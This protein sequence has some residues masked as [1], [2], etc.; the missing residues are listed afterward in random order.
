[1]KLVV[2]TP[3]YPPDIGGPATY[4]KILEDEL[5]KQ[6]VSVSVISFHTVRH[7]PK[8]IAHLVYAWKLFQALRSVDLLLALDPVSVGLPAAF[9]AF[10]SGKRFIVR[11]AGDYAWEQGKQR[12]GVKE[13]LDEF[14]Q[15]PPNRFM[16][17]VR[18]LRALQHVVASRADAV[19]VPSAYLKTIVTKWGIVPE[20]ITVVYN[21]FAGVPSLP[22][23]AEVRKRLGWS[24]P[25][26]FSSGR[27]VPWKGFGVLIGL[28]PELMRKHSGTKLYIAGS[29]PLLPE[30][31]QMVDDLGLGDMVTLLGDMPRE[32]LMAHVVAADCFVLN[33]GYEG[34]S[35][36]LLE[37]L[38]AG[39]PIVTTAVG[40]N[41][42]LIEHNV[43]GVLVDY[44]D[45]TALL[46]A[47][48]G[49]LT[50]T[51]RAR[52]MS[53]KG[54]QF[55]ANFTVERMVKDTLLVLRGITTK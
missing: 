10:L 16:A 42:E 13:N 44:N 2:A 26:I 1:M 8:G 5:P 22:L 45:A 50:D 51:V 43:T 9:A 14:V 49:V 23:R 52:E 39:T 47:I 46:R 34:F 32:E 19:I 6:G 11:I 53:E 24:A 21:A 3:L 4:A 15:M 7:L 30:L 33:T 29:G 12:F 38:S 27:L 36:Q 31:K 55:A 35:H 17:Q 41:T 18:L 20:R 40:G 48:S 37:V 28:M 54:R 25:V